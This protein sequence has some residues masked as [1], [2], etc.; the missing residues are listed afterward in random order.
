MHRAG[1]PEH[2]VKLWPFQEQMVERA[3]DARVCCLRAPPAA[4]KTTAGLALAA[5]VDVPTLVIVWTGALL[6]QWVDRCVAE[7]GVHPDWVG[8]INGDERRIGPITIGMQQTLANCAEDYAQHFGLVI[9]DE[10]QRFASD[11]FRDVIDKFAS[12]YRVGISADERRADGKEFLIYDHFGD[13]A[14]EVEREELEAAGR[15]VDVEVRVVQSNFECLWYQDIVR[16]ARFGS[17]QK[18]AIAFTRLVA[19]M[20]N[21]SARNQLIG[22]IAREHVDAGQLV[23]ALSHRR[24]HCGV[25]SAEFDRVTGGRGGVLL[26]GKDNSDEYDRAKRGLADGSVRAAA[27]TYQAFGTGMDVPSLEVGIFTTPVANSKMGQM[28]FDQFRGRFARSSA[29]KTKGIVYYVWDRAIYGQKPLKNLA[30]WCR[31][32]TVR[33]HGQWVP[34]REFL[35]RR[36]VADANAKRDQ[37]DDGTRGI[38]YDP[39]ISA[40][41]GGSEP[42]R[43]LRSRSSIRRPS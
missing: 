40:Q 21:D 35:K 7:L 10:L 3:I 25:L 20:A 9:C 37:E 8:V 11:T 16:K 1:I 12:A 32:V 36:D 26:G 43:Q 34:V 17:K 5:R 6:K 19:E 23:V 14:F 2:R 31:S 41:H 30:K 15:I 33:H 38:F 24:E 4:G 22:E 29:G 42:A 13:V 27:A 28:Q 18:V 39:R